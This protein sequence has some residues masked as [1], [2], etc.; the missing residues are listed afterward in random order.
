VQPDS[1]SLK[2]L[3]AYTRD[4]GRGVARIDYDSMDSLT[5]STGDVIEIRGGEKSK[6]HKRT[7]AK[8]LPLYPSDEGKGII[9]VDGLVRNNAGVA[10][11]DTVVVRKI[12]AIPAEKVIVAP[13]EAIPPIDERYLADALESVPLIKGDNVMVPYF[14]GR[15]TF[16]VIGVTPAGSDAVL[17][18]QK[19]A[20]NI[21]TA[22]QTP[23]DRGMHIVAYEDIGGLKDEI[24]K[25]REMIELPL[26][27]PEIFEKLGIEAPK[28][29]LLFG[30][31]GTGKT[32]LAKAVANESNSH[33]ISISGPEIMSKFYGESEARLREIF[34][35]AKEKSP[36]IIFIDEIDSIAPKRE[37]V[38]GE[39]ERRVVSQLLSLMDG[40]EGR[41]KVIVIAAT[42]R[43]NA[44]DPAL[45]RPGR[46]DREIEIKVPDKRGR[47]EI[48][49]IH[50]RNMPLDTD[51]DQDKIAGVTHGFVGADLEYLCKEA[52]M[53]CLRRLLPELNLEDEK[54]P[55]ETLEKLVINMNDFDYATREITP[56]AMREVYVEPPDVKWE[57]IGGLDNVK[58]ELQ[59]A[60]EW[61]MRFPEMYKQLGHE[62]PKGI[63]LHGPSGTGKTLLAKAV[64]TE[65]EANFISV[66]GPELLSKWVGES[67]KGIREIFRK[68]RQASPCVVFFDEIDSIAPVRGME[69]VHAST[70]RMMSQLLTEM[71]GIQEMQGVVIIAA[72]NRVDMIDN[73]LLRP[74]R[75]D[76]I[77]LVSNPD[78]NTRERILE[79]HIK[80]KPISKDIDLGRIADLTDGF[81]GA[82]MS[83][84][85][86]TAI[87]VVLQEYLA[88]YNTPEEAAKH[89]SEALVSMK[90]FEE[91]IKKIKTQR[92]MKPSDRVVMPHYR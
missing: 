84:V 26:R 90:Q 70:E 87:S 22:G 12:K 46:F 8:C 91:A 2:I 59:E 42:N 56:S 28:G 32:L 35:E 44:L 11:G 60:I 51:V 38:T 66:K 88:K 61:P 80:G 73:A 3:E 81:S 24:Q 50:A 1:F 63:L 45:R 34:K 62:V 82:D 65:S 23:A 78:R 25:V 18:T 30:P 43:P 53:K 89:T 52:A 14:G 29:V 5:A 86:N 74:G 67:E 19:T 47:L 37:E 69:G 40:L 75:F 72:T 9:R 64:A 79:I 58:R 36:S 10:I 85:A 6:S 27:H 71:D 57:D 77:V 76:K 17:V 54:V 4:V 16:Q 15:L 48:L 13:L 49:Q 68:A 31:P 41:G 33:F 20:F 7:V 83:A 92:E 55:P 39:V 21:T